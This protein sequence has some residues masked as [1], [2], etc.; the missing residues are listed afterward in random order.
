MSSR[1]PGSVVAGMEHVLCL[2]I[3]RVS[4]DSRAAYGSDYTAANR[5]KR[6]VALGSVY[7][8]VSKGDKDC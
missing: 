7:H 3:F 1:N 5:V 4:T 8:I 6:R 2:S